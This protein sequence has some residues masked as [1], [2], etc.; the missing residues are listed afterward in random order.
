[1]DI[2]CRLDDGSVRI[3]KIPTTGEDPSHA[4][5]AALHIAQRDWALSPAN[6]TRFVHGP[7]VATNAVLERKGARI[8]LITTEGFRD[9]LEIGRQMRHK[10]YELLL[11]PD[12]PVLL[13][14]C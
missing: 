10:M 11:Q 12:N 13:A 2:V 7:T 8:G 14:L 5:L 4:V 3:A 9:V 1:T 6:I